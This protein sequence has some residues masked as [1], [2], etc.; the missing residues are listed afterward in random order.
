LEN[1]NISVMFGIEGFDNA[2]VR[3]ERFFLKKVGGEL[4]QQ[5]KKIGGEQIIG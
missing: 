2:R 1:R 4:D 5:K 3:G